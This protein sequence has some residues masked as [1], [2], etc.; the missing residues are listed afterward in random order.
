MPVTL[1]ASPAAV[2]WTTLAMKAPDTLLGAADG[3]VIEL[4]RD[5]KDWREIRRWNAP[6]DRPAEQFGDTIYLAA[7]AGRLWISD[8]Q[9]HRVLVLDMATD[10]L[11][12]AFGHPEAGDDID[13]LSLPQV[14]AAR[15]IERLSTMPAI[16]GWSSSASPLWWVPHHHSRKRLSIFMCPR[17]MMPLRDTG[18]RASDMGD[19]GIRN[20]HPRRFAEVFHLL[21][22]SGNRRSQLIPWC[23][24]SHLL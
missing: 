13:H 10:K 15:G 5:G 20:D 12:A 23:I 1:R 18:A 17:R 14:I 9:R 3:K 2:R 16:N 24:N 21:T 6:Q 4:M 19:Q 11:L 7:D 22:W 8:R